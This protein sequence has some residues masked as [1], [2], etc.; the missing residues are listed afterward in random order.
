MKE[1]RSVGWILVF[2]LA[3]MPFPENLG[4]FRSTCALIALGFAIYHGIREMFEK[5]RHREIS[6]DKP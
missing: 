1:S 5:W 4:L 6:S 3:I 2:I